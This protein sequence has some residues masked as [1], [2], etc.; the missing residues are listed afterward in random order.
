MAPLRVMALSYRGFQNGGYSE[1]HYLSTLPE[2][3]I[4]FVFFCMCVGEG[5]SVVVYL[6]FLGLILMQHGYFSFRVA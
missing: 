5:R 4:P 6:R 1:K 2:G 3:I